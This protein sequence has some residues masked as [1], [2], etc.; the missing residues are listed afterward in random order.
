MMFWQ[1]FIQ[2]HDS[3]QGNSGDTTEDS[4]CESGNS[5]ILLTKLCI[6][7]LSQEILAGGTSCQPHPFSV[8][9][10]PSKAYFESIYNFPD[11]LPC[12]QG[13]V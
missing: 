9:E 1:P 8:D 2:K 7:V 4:F 13:K 10:V 5:G 3:F 11:V 12:F 6:A